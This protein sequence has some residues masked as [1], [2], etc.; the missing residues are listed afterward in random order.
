MKGRPS[1]PAKSTSVELILVPGR[2]FPDTANAPTFGAG[3]P[4]KKRRYTVARTAQGV[5]TVTLLDTFY[6]WSL[7]GLPFLQ[8]NAGAARYLQLGT[9]DQAAKTFQIRNWD[10]AAAQDVAAHANNSV[11]FCVAG[12]GVAV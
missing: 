8:L 1:W 6:E 4:T 5:W 9:I 11:G 12:Y 2:F 10:G 3:S 7:V